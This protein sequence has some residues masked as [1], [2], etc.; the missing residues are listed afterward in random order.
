MKKIFL[1]SGL[2]IVF[3]SCNTFTIK[4]ID[5]GNLNLSNEI[6]FRDENKEKIYGLYCKISGEVNDVIEIILTNNDG[7]A[8]NKI[9]PTNG[10]V[11]FIYDADWYSNEFRI[12]ILSN[13]KPGGYINEL[14][15]KS[16]HKTIEMTRL[17]HILAQLR[18]MG[19]HL[20]YL[21][22]CAKV[23]YGKTPEHVLI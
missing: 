15:L 4:N 10:R 14:L 20:G 1:L 3:S 23:M 17:D 5:I 7:L 13:N 8:S 16:N 12:K 2:F 11:N 22:S 6:I 21:H 19:F 9:I 18:H